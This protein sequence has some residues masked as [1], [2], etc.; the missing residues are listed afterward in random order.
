MER[1]LLNAIAVSTAQSGTEFFYSNP[2]HLREG[3]RS[4]ED[5]PSRRLSWYTC[6]CCPPNLARLLSSIDSYVATGGPKGLRIELYADATVEWKSERSSTT[7]SIRTSY[8]WSGTIEIGFDDEYRDDLL[9]LR[10]PRWS[11]RTLLWVDGEQ[12]DSAATDGYLEIDARDG[13]RS[14]RLDLDLEPVLEAPHPRID[15]VRGCFAVRRGPI[16][17]CLEETDLREGVSVHE[18]R[19]PRDARLRVGDMDRRVAAPVIWVDD[20]VVESSDDETPYREGGLTRASVAQ[21]TSL[22]PYFRWANREPG[23][24]RVWLPESFS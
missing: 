4:D 10:V 20:A 3:H 17:Y 16:Y 22:I 1:G 6:A 11:K 9:M 23:A 18:V 2:L 15:A 21:P 19:V 12:R 13:L 14:V 7:A 5:A 24:M 8:P